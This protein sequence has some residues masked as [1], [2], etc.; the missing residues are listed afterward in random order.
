MNRMLSYRWKCFLWI[1]SKFRQTEKYYHIISLYHTFVPFWSLLPKNTLRLI[2]RD[3][4]R[5]K[6][7]YRDI[8][9]HKKN[10]SKI[11]NSK[12]SDE[13]S[14]KIFYA[15]PRMSKFSFILKTFKRSDKP[16]LR[17]CY[18][19]LLSMREKYHRP[20]KVTTKM[21]E[22]FFQMSFNP[23]NNSHS[24]RKHCDFASV[25]WRLYTVYRGIDTAYFLRIVH[26]YKIKIVLM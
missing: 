19:P 20:F 4:N 16:S 9:E 14:H 1:C 7:W 15:E 10:K 25:Y 17:K 3:Q 24:N 8:D 12:S 11:L 26:F 22:I 13:N 18:K 2:I 6:V 21:Q 5:T 23:K